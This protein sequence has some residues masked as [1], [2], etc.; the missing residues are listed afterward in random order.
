MA[1]ETEKVEPYTFQA[2]TSKP[3]ELGAEVEVNGR[4]CC[5]IG[6]TTEHGKDGK[7]EWRYHVHPVD[8]QPYHMRSATWANDRQARVVAKSQPTT[9]ASK[10]K[11]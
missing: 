10:S 8:I 3:L 1:E 7:R 2:P 4:R 9:T 6:M 5:I 11:D